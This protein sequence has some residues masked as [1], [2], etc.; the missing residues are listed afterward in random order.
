[1]T[2]EKRQLTEQIATHVYR[3][4]APSAAPRPASGRRALYEAGAR[5]VHPAGSI[6]TRQRVVTK[7]DSVQPAAGERYI[8]RRNQIYSA[9]TRTPAYSRVVPRTLAVTGER[10][11]SGQ[12]RAVKRSLPQYHPSPVPRR[13]GLQHG[14]RRGLL[15]KVLGIFALLVMVILGAN[16]ALTGTAFRVAQVSVVGT[17]NPI[18]VQTIQRMG[19]QGQNIFLIDVAALTARIDLLPMVASASLEKQW[20]NQLQVIVVE[21]TPVLLW[22][23][24]QGTYSVDSKGV[25]IAPASETAG[26]DTLMTVVDTRNQGKGVSRQSVHPGVRLNEA[27]I[28]FAMAVFARLPKVAGISD[29]SLRYVDATS[30][31][32]HGQSN[33]EDGSYVVASKAGW[34][35]YL[36][37]P[38]DVNPLD[39]RL[40]ELQQILALVQQQQLNLATVDL[41]FGFRPVYTLK[42]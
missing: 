12:M 35:V 20:P 22:Q 39:N 26:A 7:P 31:L 1:M 3:R 23:T 16:F 38:G 25:V 8:N 13:S 17:H 30:P 32:A 18:L 21:R 28:A 42:S 11:S 29:F 24:R 40:L 6:R 41:R 27:D 34:L 14:R 10:A 36:G 2:A 15:W 4:P 9:R 19:M 37:G 33:L 5:E